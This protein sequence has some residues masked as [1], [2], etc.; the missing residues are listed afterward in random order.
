MGDYSS[1]DLETTAL[2]SV[3]EN[4]DIS[5]NCE[6]GNHSADGESEVTNELGSSSWD[7]GVEKDFQLFERRDTT[8]GFGPAG[9]SSLT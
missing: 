6:G 8:T 5:T 9:L 3:V 7:A 2:L 1:P 4:G